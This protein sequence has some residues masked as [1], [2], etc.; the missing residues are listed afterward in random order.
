MQTVPTVPDSRRRALYFLCEKMSRSSPQQ[1]YCFKL[2]V[3]WAASE[4]VSTRIN[5]NTLCLASLKPPNKLNTVGKGKRQRQ[6]KNV[7]VHF[8]KKKITQLDNVNTSAERRD[9]GSSMLPKSLETLLLSKACWV[10]HQN[11]MATYVQVCRGHCQNYI[12]LTL[13]QK[14]YIFT[15]CSPLKHT[16]RQH[17]G[18]IPCII[19]Q[20]CSTV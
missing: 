7:W 13:G 19:P 16:C 17:A 3:R 20:P 2:R 5:S 4:S 18:V 6:T 1:S 15:A 14:L 10:S 8:R 9:R 12:L 11:Q